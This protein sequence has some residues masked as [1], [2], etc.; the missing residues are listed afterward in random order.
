MLKAVIF[1]FD[2]VITDSEALHFRAFNETLTAFGV[3]ISSPEYY[4]TYLGLSDRD[5]FAT[6]IRENKIPAAPDQV[7]ALVSRK[8]AIYV[9]LARQEGQIIDGVRPFLDLLVRHKV[10]MAICS[11]ALL[12]EIEMILEQAKLRHLF[13]TIV[14]ADQ[15][16]R[17]KPDPEGF[18]LVLQRLNQINGP[19]AAR[20]C[21]VIEDS[22]WGLDAA[23]G[24]GMYTI[25]VTNSYAPEQLAMAD[26][27]VKRLDDLA[28]S[29]LQDLTR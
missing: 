28:I 8:K 21:V 6:L 29:D 19:I 16:T 22:H 24:A 13:A 12:A 17:S 25:A 15:V 4:E 23:K 18:L 26:R 2:G 20:E 27:I 5:C 3:Q 11:G 7:Q 1:D 10:T 9:A 14:S